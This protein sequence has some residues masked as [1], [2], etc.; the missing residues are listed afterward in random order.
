MNVLENES[1]PHGCMKDRKK[2]AQCLNKIACAQ[3]IVIVFIRV[4]SFY[5]YWVSNII[6]QIKT[7]KHLMLNW[8]YERKKSQQLQR[9]WLF[10]CKLSPK[11]NCRHSKRL[12]GEHG[13]LSTEHWA[14]V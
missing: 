5:C 10:V 4:I 2:Q 11:N 12:H 13:M 7:I 14:M 8:K 1:Y 9:K 6:C 3:W